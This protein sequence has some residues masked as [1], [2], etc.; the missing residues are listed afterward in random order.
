MKVCVSL[1]ILLAWCGSLGAASTD[2]IRPDNP[3]YCVV[4]HRGDSWPLD[5]FVK[6]GKFCEIYG[7]RWK[8][9]TERYSRAGCFSADPDESLGIGYQCMLC[10]KCRRRITKFKIKEVKEWEK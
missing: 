3:S 9:L 10:K 2:T 5:D 6:S 1:F 8:Q 4:N 7:H